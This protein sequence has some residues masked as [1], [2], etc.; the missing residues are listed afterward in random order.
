MS[1]IF[2]ADLNRRFPFYINDASRK[3]ASL[4]DASPPGQALID[5]SGAGPDELEMRRLGI[6]SEA[7]DRLNLDRETLARIAQGYDRLV[8][9]C[10]S[11]EQARTLTCYAH[12]G[13]I[14]GYS[15]ACAQSA[16]YSLPDGTRGSI[17]ATNDW[18][19][20]DGRK[21][22]RQE[23]RITLSIGESGRPCIDVDNRLD[24]RAR[25]VLTDG[26][27]MP[28]LSADSYAQAHFRAELNEDGRLALLESPS[29]RYDIRPDDF[30]KEYPLPTVAMLEATERSD[31]LVEDALRYA[32]S[33]GAA[34]EIHALRAL[35]AF[36]REPTGARAGAVVS[37]CGRLRGSLSIP[38]AALDVLNRAEW[39][40]YTDQPEDFAQDPDERR[41]P[42]ALFGDLRQ[43]LGAAIGQNVLPGMIEAIRLN[44]L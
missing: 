17:G 7:A 30:Q 35:V 34:H 18:S 31:A 5:W 38:K 1:R 10:G 19:G 8:E 25:F 22:S 40:I 16:A 12:Q 13:I 29:Y 37:A 14:A 44:Q 33:I 21:F 2:V 3:D 43:R 36:E 20:P 24:G 28:F 11:E 39:G 9:F 6:T 42:P 41:L 15:V 26:G 23:T 32:D 27:G 4:S